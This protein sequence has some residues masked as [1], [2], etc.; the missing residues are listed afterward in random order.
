MS[1]QHTHA[2]EHADASTTGVH[3]MLLFGE[4]V[5]YLSH[6]PMFASPHNFQ[7]LLEVGL[8][9]AA[10]EAFLSGDDVAAGDSIHTFAPQP[11]PI[12]ELDP[13]AD[14]PG[15]TSIEGTIFRG[16]FERGGEP[17]AEDV[18]AEVHR[19]VHFSE[20]DE[21]AKR[22]EVRELTYLCFGRP[23]HLYLAHEVTARPDFDQVLEASL[24]PDTVTNQAGHALPE[25]VATIGFDVAQRV[26]FRGRS[27]TPESRLG[28]HAHQIFDAL[29]F[30]TS[31]LTGAHGFAVR[32]LTHTELYI[33]VDE[34]T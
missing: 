13:D 27:D 1:H 2:G 9:D 23:G 16:H 32:M 26:L 5:L 15:R 18:V 3:G 14:G 11:F 21:N 20:L 8:D 6:L 12:V 17:I 33:E 31:S 25:D 10:R 28:P 19:V 30:Q 22:S 7:V 4:D 34:L 29:F 24:S